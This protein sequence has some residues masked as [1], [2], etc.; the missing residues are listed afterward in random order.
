MY[1][2]LLQAIFTAALKELVLNYLIKTRLLKK[3]L[4]N[5][6]RQHYYF[7]LKVQY[8][9]PFKHHRTLVSLIIRSTAYEEVSKRETFLAVQ[10]LISNN[11][12]SMHR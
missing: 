2:S 3:L 1:K 6:V 4:S 12:K 10:Y 9:L 8:H 5:F 7:L 11:L